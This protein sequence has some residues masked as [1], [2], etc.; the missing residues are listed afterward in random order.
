VENHHAKSKVIVGRIPICLAEIPPLK[1]WR[2][3]VRFADGTPKES[4][5]R[6]GHLHRVA[7]DER[8]QR[9]VG[10]KE[11]ALV[12]IAH[13]V[14]AGV[15]GL[16]HACDVG[17]G[18]DQIIPGKSGSYPPPVS[19]VVEFQ[20]R[21]IRGKVRAVHEKPNAVPLELVEENVVRP[22]DGDVPLA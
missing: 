18:P 9:A 15:D 3:E 13:H 22:A 14:A 5:T 17:G 12:D 16:N 11:V 7:I 19:R 1:L 10:Y 4:R 8:N 21:Y 6:L 20:D 2:R